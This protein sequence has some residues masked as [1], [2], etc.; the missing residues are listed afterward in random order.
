MVGSRV[1]GLVV[2][3]SVTLA[4]CAG[5]LAGIWQ[6]PSFWWEANPA[7]ISYVAGPASATVGQ[8]VV[9]SARVLIGSSSCDRFK[10]LQAR[11]EEASRSVVLVGTRESKRSNGP[12]ACTS[13][14]GAKLATVSVTF[15]AAGAWRV[16][17]ERFA[18]TSFAVDEQPRATIDI[19]VNSN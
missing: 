16:S 12:L 15:P 7:E 9:L 11:V 4:G 13:D 18:S 17:V 1:L 5:G 10:D 8:P 14:F 2:G 19:Q 3:L 6:S